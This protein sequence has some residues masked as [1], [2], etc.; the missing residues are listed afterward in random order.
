MNDEMLSVMERH[1]C[2]WRVQMSGGSYRWIMEAVVD[3]TGDKV[4]FVG[5][6]ASECYQ[7]AVDYARSLEAPRG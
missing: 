4:T 5:N 6:R 3:D 7:Q 2:D 1:Y